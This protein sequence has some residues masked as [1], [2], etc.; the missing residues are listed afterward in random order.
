MT[1]VHLGSPNC[2]LRSHS[3]SM[4]AL[5]DFGGTRIVSNVS[6]WASSRQPVCLS[7]AK[8]PS[9]ENPVFIY[10]GEDITIV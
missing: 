2:G 6:N 1:L 10:I 5:G 3:Y 4:Q 8:D 7:N 9:I